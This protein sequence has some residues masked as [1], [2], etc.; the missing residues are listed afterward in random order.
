MSQYNVSRK[1]LV[2]VSHMRKLAQ[3]L[4]LLLQRQ[5]KQAPARQ[6]L[7]LMIDTDIRPKEEKRGGRKLA[8]LALLS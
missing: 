4:P 2:R 7:Y 3:H 8:P 6:N 5:E 1:L